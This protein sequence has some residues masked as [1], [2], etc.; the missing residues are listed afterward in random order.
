MDTLRLNCKYSKSDCLIIEGDHKMII[1]AP[2]LEIPNDVLVYKIEDAKQ[3]RDYL[4][5]FIKE[6]E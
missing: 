2:K 1:F 4:D 3:L 5:Q 6:N